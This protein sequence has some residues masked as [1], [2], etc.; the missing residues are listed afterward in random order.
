MDNQFNDTQ[1]N[2]TPNN[3]DIFT[4][5]NAKYAQENSCEQN[6]NM[7]QNFNPQQ[8]GNPYQN[9]NSQ[10]SGN[11]YQNYNSQQYGNP[12]QQPN[13]GYNQNFN[14]APNAGMDTSPMTL[15]DWLLTLLAMMIPCAGIILYFVWAFG[16]HG[17]INRRNFC[18]AQLIIMGVILA[19]YLVII[20]VLGV[21]VA[22]AISTY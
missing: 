12:Y 13:Y 3:N 8:N 6:V 17:N 4:D 11:P 2:Q 19:L 7:N 9:Y 14:N 18:R 21:S 20:L 5:P 1:E 22:G 15:G 10:Q 16:S